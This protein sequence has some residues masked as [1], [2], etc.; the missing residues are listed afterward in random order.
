MNEHSIPP[1]DPSPQVDETAF[2]GWYR[3]RHARKF[4]LFPTRP[5][6]R[7]YRSLC[8][9]WYL[10]DVAQGA[11]LHDAPTPARCCVQCLREQEARR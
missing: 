8:D 9:N 7:R 6:G 11:I 2:P 3:P 1:S 5:Y 4:H 10:I